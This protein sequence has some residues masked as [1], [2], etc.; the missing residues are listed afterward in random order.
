MI[1]SAGV[2]P[3]TSPG[4]L[5]RNPLS[6]CESGRGFLFGVVMKPR[7]MQM[8]AFNAWVADKIGV[9][10]AVVL[11]C[12][13]YALNTYGK[14]D[15]EYIV[16]EISYDYLKKTYAYMSEDQLL[17]SF[18]AIDGYFGNLLVEFDDDGESISVSYKE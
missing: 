11:N 16:A 7:K 4:N 10:A 3:L 15:G 17:D 12:F 13:E 6:L 5:I 1:R 2:S 9:N 18:K 8:H 14:S